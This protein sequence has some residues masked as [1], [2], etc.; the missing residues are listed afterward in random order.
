V[1]VRG[2]EVA[3]FCGDRFQSG[4][5]G[6]VAMSV[7]PF[8]QGCFSELLTLSIVGFRYTIRV[9]R[10]QIAGLELAFGDRAIPISKQAQQRCGGVEAHARVVGAENQRREMSA[11]GVPEALGVIVV[12]GKEERGICAVTGVL[13]KQAVDRAQEE[14]GMSLSQRALAAQ[15]GLQVC[16][17][18]GGGDAFARDI[19][20]DQSQ[21]SL[22]QVKKVKVIPSDLASLQAE[23]CVFESLSV[24]MDLREQPGLDLFRD[25]HFLRGAAFGF[26]FLCEGSAVS[27]HAPSEFVE[28][29]EAEGVAVGVFEAG[30]DSAPGRDLRWVA[31]L[32]AT[33]APF[34]IFAGD[35]FR[36]EP[37]ESIML[38]ERIKI[39]PGSGKGQADVSIAVGRSDFNPSISVWKSVVNR[40][41]EPEL[42]GVET[43]ASIKV[44]HEDD[45][46][47]Q[48]EIGILTVNAK[49]RPFNAKRKFLGS[50]RARLY[51]P[52]RGPLGKQI[53]SSF[54]RKTDKASRL[55]GLRLKLGGFGEAELAF[56]QGSREDFFHLRFVA[57]ARHGEFADDEVAGALQ[58]LLFA[59]RKRFGL[60]Q[61]DQALEDTGDLEQRTGAHA[62]G[63]FLE[64]VFPVAVAAIF[65]YGQDVQN[66]LDFSIAD[67]T[68]QT[69]A[70]GILAR[71]H[72]LEAARFDVKEVKPFDCGTY[73][74][75]ADLLDNPN[76]VIGID[77]L[78]TDVKVQVRTTHV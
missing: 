5:A 47:M 10:Q 7:Q 31:E 64:A 3:D 53:P 41:V 60:V 44:V 46:E 11:V 58:H 13:V 37:D 71:Y 59:K 12:F 66:F 36:D 55:C 9:E 28:S 17:E 22:A 14:F 4:L 65:V 30:V 16:H 75:A 57:I 62:V 42:V 52:P 43:E 72:H 8:Y 32:N 15:V 63:I 54:A 27:F 49:K 61:R 51:G 68:A 33:G 24:G 73:R 1:L 74:A 40:H 21:L 38:D 76:A 70:A 48:A 39:H 45:D 69:Y 19:S 2:V 56:R 20:D 35:V 34:V 25:F 67:Y 50:H 6:L 77:N 78:V 23:A 18:K 29:G 26:E